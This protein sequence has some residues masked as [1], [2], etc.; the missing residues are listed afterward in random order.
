MEIGI[1]VSGGSAIATATTTT[2]TYYLLSYY[3]LP[4]TYYLLSCYLL[5]LTPTTLQFAQTNRSWRLRAVPIFEACGRISVRERRR[6]GT[7]PQPAASPPR[8][9]CHVPKPTFSSAA[10][11]P[12]SHPIRV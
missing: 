11:R 10:R 1:L 3:L 5:I 9:V 4:T 7:G 6:Y 12:E 2:T 8:V